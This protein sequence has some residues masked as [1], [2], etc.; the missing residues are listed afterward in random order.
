LRG[1][2]AAVRDGRLD[3][4]AYSGGAVVLEALAQS[5]DEVAGPGT[6]VG[7]GAV[8]DFAVIPIEF[9]QENAGRRQTAVIDLASEAPVESYRL[10]VC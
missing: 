3:A 7:D 4:E 5:E 6:E 2:V 8:Q 1:A 10:G 9:A